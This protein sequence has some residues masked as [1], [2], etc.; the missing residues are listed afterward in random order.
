MEGVQSHL[1]GYANRVRLTGKTIIFSKIIQTLVARRERVLVL[2]HRDELIRQAQDKLRAVT[3]IDCAIEKADETA[4]ESLFPVTVGSVQTLMRP[5]RL[6]RFS[7]DHYD[8]VI[9]DEAHHALADSYQRVLQHFCGA[10]VLGVTATPDRGDKRNLGQFFDDVA[11]EYTLPDAV[12]DGYLC[13]IK[14]QTIPLRIDLGGVRV[15]AGDYNDKD[16]GNALDPYLEQIADHMAAAAHDRKSVAFLPLIATSM[17]LEALLKDRGISVRHIDGTSEDRRDILKWFTAAGPGS[18]LCNSMLLTEGWD[19]PSADCIVVLRPTKVR[20]LYT[21]MVGRGT[22]I[23]PGKDDLLL[24]DFLWMSEKHSLCKPAHLVAESEEIAAKMIE[25]QDFGGGRRDLFETMAEA[26]TEAKRARESALAKQ[27]EENRMRKARLI[28][29]VEWAISIHAE[30]L[31]MYEPVFKWQEQRPTKKQIEYLSGRGFDVEAVLNRGHASALID[32][33]VK[34]SQENYATPKQVKLLARLGVQ[35]P[36]R[37][38]FADAKDLIDR[39][40]KNGWRY[41]A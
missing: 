32:A 34:R 20:S 5:S 25:A 26:K 10:K 17:K 14:A 24:L 13:P 38:R 22:R 39:I 33:I 3:G 23:H 36:E 9:V 29:P 16:L 18:V 40:A 7:Q 31:E 2:A 28:N 27:L 4:R 1:V 12:N 35:N 8:T 30:Q 21:Q 15:T 19:E 6:E 41:V 11:Y 37:L